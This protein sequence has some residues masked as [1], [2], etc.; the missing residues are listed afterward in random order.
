MD[1]HEELEIGAEVDRALRAVAVAVAQALERA[2]RAGSGRDRSTAHEIRVEWLGQRDA[3][4][5]L[6]LPWTRPGAVERADALPAARAWSRAVGWAGQDPT[7]AEAATDLAERITV[8]HGTGPE[9]I[10]RH[11]QN[12]PT[13]TDRGTR[14]L[15]RPLKAPPAQRMSP[16]QARMLAKKHAPAY[17]GRHEDP[18]T[19][20]G[21]RRLVADWQAWRDDGELP[22][23]TRWEAWATYT[24]RGDD[25][26]PARYTDHPA[27][28]PND[29]EDAAGRNV[30]RDAEL[31]LH[32]QSGS[33]ERGLLELTAHDEALAAAQMDPALAHAA[34]YDRPTLDQAPDGGQGEQPARDEVETAAARRAVYAGL[35]DPQEFA[36]ADPGVAAE[37]WRVAREDA[38]SDSQAFAATVQLEQQFATRWKVSPE[39]YLADAILDQASARADAERRTEN[40]A[41]TAEEVAEIAAAAPTEM[42]MPDKVAGLRDASSK[43]DRDEDE[44]VVTSPQQDGI[45]PGQDAPTTL[46]ATTDVVVGAERSVESNDPP[47]PATAI[48]QETRVEGVGVGVESIAPRGSREEPGQRAL[49]GRDSGPPDAA[50]SRE[51]VLELNDMAAKWFRDRMGPG[52]PG[53]QYLTSR[54][55][56]DAVEQGRWQLGYAPPGWTH[57]TD[58]LRRQGVSNQEMLDAGLGSMSSRHQ[59][60]DVFRDRAVLGVR[61]E[62]G[63]TVGF[64]GRDLSGDERAPKYLNTGSTSAFRKSELVFGLHEAGP[65]ARLVRVEGP[66]DAIAVTEAGQDGDRAVAGVSPMGTALTDQQAELITAHTRTSSHPDRD[67][68]D[69]E[70]GRVWVGNDSDT[71]GRNATARDHWVLR[72]HGLNP[73]GVVWPGGND[74]AELWERDPDLL[75]SAVTT[76]ADAPSTALAAID[77]EHAE[78]SDRLATGEA[79]A[80]EQFA[81]VTDLAVADLPEQD[82]RAGRRHAHGLLIGRDV[83]LEAKPPLL[84]DMTEPGVAALARVSGQPAYDRAAEL[85]LTRVSA[86]ARTA[87]IESSR[88]FACSTQG[89]LG[90]VAGRRSRRATRD[91]QRQ[92]LVVEQD[93]AERGAMSRRRRPT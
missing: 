37:A 56:A 12:W 40:R 87:R 58:H 47:K 65:S 1:M 30:E 79:D 2:A 88:G 52:S 73:R 59:V 71:A 7:A 9:E 16:A 5:A 15:A 69:R 64:V 80:H 51:R 93:V 18:A 36:R 13:R 74:P 14:S 81:A 91:G 63:A 28:G 49:A 23:R 44:A 50:T 43:L 61:D 39:T 24:G 70:D 31:E 33:D 72:D 68:N 90:E 78:L 89:M 76:L 10:L 42:A 26:D 66:F 21:D 48:G 92:V 86:Q 20:E 3:A 11:P 46:D 77:H 41:Q 25:F 53:H 84:T 45:A 55:G 62:G 35:L 32:W 6:Y 29:P 8:R 34:Q 60:I 22:A 54:L 82:Q 4:R 27:G 38:S 85:D 67:G 57:L 17:Y 75:R 83:G 19:P